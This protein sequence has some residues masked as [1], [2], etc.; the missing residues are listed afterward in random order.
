MFP[1][2]CSL[3]TGTSRSFQPAGSTA[4]HDRV[5]LMLGERQRY[6]SQ[7]GSDTE[8]GRLF[9]LPVEDPDDVDERRREVGLPPLAEY[10]APFASANGGRPLEILPWPIQ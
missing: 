6:G 8:S 9:V 10:T 5:H 1:R 4:V 7:I 3:R 2:V